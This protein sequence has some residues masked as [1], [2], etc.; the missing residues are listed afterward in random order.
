MYEFERNE[1]FSLYLKGWRARDIF[2]SFGVQE[3]ELKIHKT[4][5]EAKMKTSGKAFEFVYQRI[6]PTT[7]YYG[8]ITMTKFF[9]F[10][11]RIFI[12]TFRL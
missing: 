6:Y 3:K 2:F 9:M 7:I 12:Y 1:R 8:R 4:F 11:D 5:I 10:Y